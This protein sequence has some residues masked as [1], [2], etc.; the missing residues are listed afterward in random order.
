MVPK[1]TVRF[2]RFRYRSYS[3]YGSGTVPAVPVRSLY[4]SYGFRMVLTV[5]VPVPQHCVHLVTVGAGWLL[6]AAL[7]LV[8]WRGERGRRLRYPLL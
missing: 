8:L 2:L 3:S 6:V 7:L 4:G 5:P 1:V